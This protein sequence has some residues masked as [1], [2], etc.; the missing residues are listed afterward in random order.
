MIPVHRLQV[1]PTVCLVVKKD[2]D[3]DIDHS[4]EHL[5]S[6]RNRNIYSK[7]NSRD[8]DSESDSSS[9]VA[10]QSE[11]EDEDE[12]EDVLEEGGEY[13]DYEEAYSWHI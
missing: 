1:D 9:E 13:S 6:G 2:K 11:I 3:N 7:F 12:E 4:E 10:D 5:V 8:V